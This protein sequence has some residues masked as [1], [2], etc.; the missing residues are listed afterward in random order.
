MAP[1]QYMPFFGMEFFQATEGYPDSYVAGY[2]RAI[3]HYWTHSHCAGLDDNDDYLR[4]LCRIDG[5][6]WV[7]AKPILFGRF[8]H[9]EGGKWHQK[10]CKEI[11]Y[12]THQLYLN[13]LNQTKAATQARIRAR[14]NGPPPR[15]ET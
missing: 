6:E 14:K 13:R 8:F 2:L 4:K 3:W 7:Q 12:R 1:D 9:K 15:K 11:W 10:K 5:V